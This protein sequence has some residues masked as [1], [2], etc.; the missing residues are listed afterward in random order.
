MG[1]QCCTISIDTEATID[2]SI[3]GIRLMARNFG[4]VGML[5]RALLAATVWVIQ[6]MS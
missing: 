5:K 1:R 4:T 3:Y 6:D 2:R